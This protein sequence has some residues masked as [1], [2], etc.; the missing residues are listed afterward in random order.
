MPDRFIFSMKH[1]EIFKRFLKIRDVCSIQNKAKI[2]VL[3]GK[4]SFKNLQLYLVLQKSWK[5]I[6]G[7]RVKHYDHAF[8][9][10]QS[11]ILNKM[12]T[13]EMFSSQQ[14]VGGMQRIITA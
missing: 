2:I 3:I 11:R 5:K 6:L 8:Y 9:T 1:R 13:F 10:G 4:S 12:I 7:I 14:R